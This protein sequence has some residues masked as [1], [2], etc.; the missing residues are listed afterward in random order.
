MGEA[1]AHL[2]RLWFQQQLLRSQDADGVYRFTTPA[3]APA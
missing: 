1:V 3:A 2:H